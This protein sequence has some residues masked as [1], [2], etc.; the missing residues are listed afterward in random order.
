[1]IV[2]VQFVSRLSE[3]YDAQVEALT[4][5]NLAC[6][7][8]LVIIA[9]PELPPI[10]LLALYEQGYSSLLVRLVESVLEELGQFFSFGL[11]MPKV[12]VYRANDVALQLVTWTA[13]DAPAASLRLRVGQHFDLERADAEE[14]GSWL[15]AV[16]ESLNF[17]RRRTLYN[18]ARV[19]E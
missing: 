14:S 18:H 5:P 9:L 15:A 12:H 19:N 11:I 8:D 3:G 13:A 10:F 4:S 17:G 2:T 6:L 7:R 16:R 1:M